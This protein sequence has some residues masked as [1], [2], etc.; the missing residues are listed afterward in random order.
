MKIYH[1]PRCGK[2]RTA[3]EILQERGFE[4]EIIEYLKTPPTR[5]E[6]V[7]LI[8]DSGLTVREI[9]RSQEAVFG[10][11]GLDNPAVTDDQLIDAMLEH[12]ILMNRPIVVTDKGTRLC[13]PGTDV[14][15]LL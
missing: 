12:P 14:L 3:L 15:E 5:D 6:L 8:H 13:R 1:N 7:K 2:S 9:M 4:P 11:L 10:E